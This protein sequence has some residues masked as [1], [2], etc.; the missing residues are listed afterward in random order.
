MSRVTGVRVVA[1]GAAG[2]V[3]LAAVMVGHAASVGVSGRTVGAG[4]ATVP[5]CD[6]DG[7]N[8]SQ[9][10]SGMNV[11]TVTVSGIAATCAGGTMSVTVNNGATTA[12]S[13]ALVPSGG[14]SLPFV[15]GIAAGDAEQIDVLVT[16]P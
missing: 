14:G 10:V 3:V 8:V 13:T 9:A 2:L 5:A 7:F 4:A 11:G 16:G 1:L 6:S 12:T 15:F